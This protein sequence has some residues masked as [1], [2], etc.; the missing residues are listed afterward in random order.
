MYS[1]YQSEKSIQ[2][3][4]NYSGCAF[5]EQRTSTAGI[6]PTPREHFVPPTDVRRVEVA[7]PTLS[8][9]PCKPLIPPLSEASANAEATCNNEPN[10]SG[11]S[12]LSHFGGLGNA[13]FLSKG[14]GFEELLLLGLIIL[15][16][17]SEQSS[18]IVLWLALL[19]F[20]D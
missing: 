18:D 12:G 17:Q 20:C 9:A 14:L 13:S 19:L 4:K 7:K 10:G 16:S 6:K 8:E 3:P 1:R 11:L 15:L 5:P 2:I